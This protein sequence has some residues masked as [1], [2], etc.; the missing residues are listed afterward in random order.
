MSI[1]DPASEAILDPKGKKKGDSALCLHLGSAGKLLFFGEVSCEVLR[2]N[3]V[4]GSRFFT[5]IFVWKL[6]RG[7]CEVLR[8]G[9]GSEAP[10]AFSELFCKF[11]L[12]SPNSEALG[13]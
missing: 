2:Q 7:F 9:R 12:S 3:T 11:G 8:R 13:S 5:C 1:L 4:L 10:V 6:H